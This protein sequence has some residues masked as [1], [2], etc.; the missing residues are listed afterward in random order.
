MPVA[1]LWL[2]CCLQCWRLNLDGIAAA[3]AVDAVPGA[4]DVVAGQ[5]QWG[6]PSC[7]SLL[8]CGNSGELQFKENS[9]QISR[10]RLMLL[11][12]VSRRTRQE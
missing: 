2:L 5:G 6:L 1:I 10:L 4:G 12:L 11:L 8:S 3:A 9:F 7:P